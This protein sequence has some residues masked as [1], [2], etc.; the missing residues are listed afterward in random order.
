[1]LDGLD[2][3]LRWFLSDVRGKFPDSPVLLADGS[4]GALSKPLNSQAN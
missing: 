2:L 1:M 3:V 4:G